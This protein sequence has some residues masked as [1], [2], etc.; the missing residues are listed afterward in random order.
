MK[1]VID[2][3][4]PFIRGVFDEI[5]DVVY[6][7]GDAIGPGDVKDA[8]GLIVRTRT[9]CNRALLEGSGV[10]FIA[11]ATIGYDHIDNGWC[12]ANGI[13]WTNAPGCNS[14]SVEQY[15]VSVLL[16]L[17][18]LR[19]SIPAEKTL[20]IVGVGN[21]GTKVA[22]AASALGYKVLLNDPPR[23]RAE[24]GEAFTALDELLRKADIVTIHVPLS[25]QGDFPT[26]YMADKHLF[27]AMKQGAVFINTSRGEVVDEAALKN[28][29]RSGKLSAAVLDVYENEPAVDRE[30]ISLLTFA[31]PHIAGYSTDGKANG[32]AMSVRAV[33]RFFG[34]GL[35]DWMPA[36]VP[37]PDQAEL[38]AD[39]SGKDVSGIVQEVYDATYEVRTDHENFIAHPDRFEQLRGDYRTRREPPAYHVRVFNDDGTYRELFENLRFGVIGD[40]CF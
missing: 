8:D 12:E 35:D 22:R 18:Q 30:L 9:R 20:G 11:T 5:A 27:S 26:R 21:V 28:A 10:K 14:G 3:K 38:F 15:I 29:L 33:S 37:Q 36:D 19:E 31:T 16:G 7:P 39:G 34:L 2:H 6:L 17:P 25:D 40:S 32:T 23:A 24:G 1:L 4:I 13:R